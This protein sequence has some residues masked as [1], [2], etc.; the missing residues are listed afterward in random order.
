[1]H[2]YESIWYLQN[3]IRSFKSQQIKSDK[4]SP[5]WSPEKIDISQTLYR[6]GFEKIRVLHVGPLKKPPIWGLFLC[7]AFFAT[8]TWLVLQLLPEINLC[9]KLIN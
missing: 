6:R 8:N 7:I 2:R 3:Y 9:E 4:K 5:I 1:M